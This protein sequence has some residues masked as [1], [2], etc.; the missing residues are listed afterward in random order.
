[1]QGLECVIVKQCT[2]FVNFDDGALMHPLFL[3]PAALSGFS[4]LLLPEAR[5]NLITEGW[6]R[7]G[8]LPV[9]RAHQIVV[10]PTSPSG[11]GVDER[12]ANLFLIDLP[13]YPCPLV[14][15]PLSDFP[16]QVFRPRSCAGADPRT[17]AMPR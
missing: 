5:E 16:I 13:V 12:T 7:R 15:I 6:V 8:S 3:I 2:V 4:C 17:S 1:M 9:D 10:A 14:Y 11:Q